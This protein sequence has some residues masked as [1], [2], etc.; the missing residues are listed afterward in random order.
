MDKQNDQSPSNGQTPIEDLTLNQ[1]RTEEV[2]G[3]FDVRPTTTYTIMVDNID[4]KD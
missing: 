1:D 3:G 2:K 4:I